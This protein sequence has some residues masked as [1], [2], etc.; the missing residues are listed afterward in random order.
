MT[1][2]RV[3]LF[4][5][6]LQLWSPCALSADAGTNTHAKKNTKDNVLNFEEDVFEGEKKRPDLFLGLDTSEVE[7]T[8]FIF[9]RPNFNDFFSFDKKYRTEFIK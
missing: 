5:M 3:C 1:G 8:D 7:T 9:Q 4:L 2:I 6:L